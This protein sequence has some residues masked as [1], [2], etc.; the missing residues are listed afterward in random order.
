[1]VPKWLVKTASSDAIKLFLVFAG[2]CN[3]DTKTC[4]PSKKTLLEETGFSENHFYK[5]RNEL[6]ELGAVIV[7]TRKTDVNVNISSVITLNYSQQITSPHTVGVT[8]HHEGRSPHT[9]GV[10]HLT[11][12]GTELDSLNYTNR[13]ILNA[14][15]EKSGLAKSQNT[16]YEN[17]IGILNRV[18]KK[19]FALYDGN[20][21]PH[22][23]PLVAL[24]QQ[25]ITT[26]TLPESLTV[27][28]QEAECIIEYLHK[29]WGN[30]EKMKQYLRPSTVFQRD[31]WQERLDLATESKA[32][33]QPAKGLQF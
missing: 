22:H 7:E 8:S 21:K 20:G 23:K 2:Y 11:P 33:A 17:L 4:Y 19:N 3:N 1:M 31:K 27:L 12:C 14:P 18:C 30:D 28:Q 6:V 15:S 16:S 9:V 24:I 25:K 13:T 29:Q 5:C 10:G 26:K 32:P